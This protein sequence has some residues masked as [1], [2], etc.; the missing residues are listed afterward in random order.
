VKDAEGGYRLL[1]LLLLMMDVLE[2]SLKIEQTLD[3]K[4]KCFTLCF[5]WTTFHNQPH[6]YISH[7]LSLSIVQLFN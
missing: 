3:Y 5:V 1:L 6:E 4:Y 2:A 7:T